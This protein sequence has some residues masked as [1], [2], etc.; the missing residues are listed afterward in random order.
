[1]LPSETPQ[2]SRIA[3]LAFDRHHREA[4]I[5]VV[6]RTRSPSMRSRRVTKSSWSTM[7]SDWNREA[8]IGELLPDPIME[9][10]L[11]YA[12][13]PPE[14]L[15]TLM[16]EVAAHQGKAGTDKNGEMPSSRS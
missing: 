8:T 2:F 4:Q 3:Q 6:K 12:C 9:A 11:R 7:R 10:V 1:V 13:T 5:T 14:K 15:R 16:H